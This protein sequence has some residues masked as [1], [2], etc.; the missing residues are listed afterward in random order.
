MIPPRV[1]P[2]VNINS[3]NVQSSGKQTR[4]ERR[5]LTRDLSVAKKSR[6]R[7]ETVEKG[8]KFD[9]GRGRSRDRWIEG[10]DSSPTHTHDGRSAQRNFDGTA[11]GTRKIHRSTMSRLELRVPPDCPAAAGGELAS[12]ESSKFVGAV[13]SLISR[14]FAPTRTSIMNLKDIPVH[15]QIKRPRA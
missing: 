13:A 12:A 9:A 1:H 6:D 10:G 4:N 7:D 5:G 11:E 3:P 2:T 15:G 14:L 8:S